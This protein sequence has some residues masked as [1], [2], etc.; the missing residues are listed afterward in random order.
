MRIK[1]LL[2]ALTLPVAAHAEQPLSAI[3]WLAQNARPLTPAFVEPPVTP[4]AL[5][6]EVEVAP[7]GASP[8]A[9]GLIPPNVTGLPLSLW[10]MSDAEEVA[11]LLRDVSVDDTPA[12]QTLLYTLLLA[13]AYSAG[14]D[15]QDEALLLARLDRLM[16]LGAV[17]PAEAL[18]AA[19]G[20]RTV[21][22]RFQ[23]WFDATLLTG[24]EDTSCAALHSAPYLMS[25]YPARIFC[26]ARRG[27]WQTAALTLEIAHSLNLLPADQLALLDRFLSPDIY[28]G[29]PPL[30]VP[31]MPDPLT[32]RLYE[33]IGE[34]LPT[35]PL[36]RAFAHADLRDVAG[37][38][39]QIEAAERLTRI[40][41]L[42]PNRLL[43]LY[44][45]RK[46]AASGGVWD[47]VTAL[48]RFE[49]ALGTQSGEAVAKTLPAVWDAMQRTELEVAFA[50]LF[51]E[52][53]ARI[54]LDD[55]VAQE[56]AWYV[57]LLSPDY[58]NAALAPRVTGPR[59]EFLSTLALGTP[60]NAPAGDEIA[61]AIVDGFA[62]DAA[63]PPRVADALNKGRLG[64]AI[65]RSMTY[66]DQGARGNPSVLSGAIAALR[67]VGLENTA[68]RASLQ[69][70]LLERRG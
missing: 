17:D 35:A 59:A 46:A 34:R 68:R 24:Q 45:D 27:D 29:A 19:A 51:A 7:I 65:L 60:R 1:A 55:P 5:R 8:R 41:A 32:F 14:N 9:F 57:H 22:E 16:A 63:L 52:P 37:W 48:Q 40:G 4:T 25:S 49:T 69:L 21:P 53:L 39:A 56:I 3:D 26:A 20:A 10:Q 31:D 38:K 33:T 54:A 36:P 43:G 50:D 42:P 13:E 66:F 67:Q 6:P 23:R 47:R 28:E 64:E 11:T 15:T 18:G 30:P 61:Q 62:A 70:M 12:M 58:E 44:T 2:L